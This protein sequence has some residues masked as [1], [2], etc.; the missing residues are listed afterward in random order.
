M[1]RLLALAAAA[2]LTLH[3]ARA[4]PASGDEEAAFYRGKSIRLIVGSGAGDSFDLYGRLVSRHLADH[5]PGKPTV[6]VQNMQGAGSLNALNYLMNVAPRDG[7]AIGLFIPV[8]TIQPLLQPAVARFDPRIIDWLGSLATDYYTCGFWTPDKITV[9]DLRSR[10]FVVGS[11]AVAGATYAGTR[12]FASVLG[13]KLRLVPGYGTMNDLNLAAERGEVQ[14]HCGLMATSLKSTLWQPFLDGRLQVVLRASLTADATLPDVPNAFDLVTSEADRQVLL[15]LAGPWYYGRPLAAPPDLPPE[16]LRVLR[17]AF[18]EM[19]ED[20]AFLAD[21]K[22]L[23]AVIAPLSADEVAGTI[24]K[25]YAIP[26]SVIQRA[27]PLF[28]VE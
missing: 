11:T 20:P 2:C 24:R 3:A 25:I 23:N 15:L 8:A 27:R 18:T 22:Q 10:E 28:G 9:G 4:Q 17:K 14:G 21:A 26:P 12:V 7:T 19:L 1:K 13:L 5:I 6:I 16:R